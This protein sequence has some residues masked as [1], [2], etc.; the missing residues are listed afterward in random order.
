M[1]YI[2]NHAYRKHEVASLTLSRRE[3][4]TPLQSAE[5]LYACTVL[6][7]LCQAR[8]WLITI[9]DPGDG[10]NEV[11]NFVSG[12]NQSKGRYAQR[13][14]QC[15][16]GLRIATPLNICGI[17][18]CWSSCAI[19]SVVNYVEFSALSERGDDAAR[20]VCFETDQGEIGLDNC[21]VFSITCTCENMTSLLAY[22]PE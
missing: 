22:I 19:H 15:S 3:P 2:D 6:W 14:R 17:R 16:M 8:T 12:L 21:K 5:I 7:I 13:H 10:Y 18:H 1:V 11:W 4:S 20:G 9:V